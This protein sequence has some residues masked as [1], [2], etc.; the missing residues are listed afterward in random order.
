MNAH[1][2]EVFDGANDDAVVRTISHY[3]HLKLFP[4]EERLVDQQFVR[5]GKIQ[6]SRANLDKFI[7]VVGNATARSAKG[8]TGANDTGKAQS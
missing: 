4:A 5:G 6:P 2:I 7:Q 3:F 1:G 8:K